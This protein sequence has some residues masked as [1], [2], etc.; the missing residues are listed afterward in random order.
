[1]KPL[2]PA[3]SYSIPGFRIRA[4]AGLLVYI[5]SLLPIFSFAQVGRPFIKN[6]SSEEIGAAAQ[7]WCI[8]QDSVG[9]LYF[10]NSLGVIGFNGIDWNLKQVSNTS[11]VR[12]L[13]Y[14]PVTDRLY[15]G[16]QGEFGYFEKDSLGNRK[17]V[18]LL[19]QVPDEDKNFKDIWKTYI[20]P[21]GIYFQSW[22]QVFRWNGDEMDIWKPEGRFHQSFFVDNTFWIKENE[23]GLLLMDHDTLHLPKGGEF[24]ASL[25]IYSL[26]PWKNGS[27]I[28]GTREAGFFILSYKP[29]LDSLQVR[30]IYSTEKDFILKNNLYGGVRLRNGQYLFNTTLGG[31]FFLGPEGNITRNLNKSNGLDIDNIKAIFEDRDGSIWLATNSGITR[32]DYND[33]VTYLGEI[34]NLN[35]E[36]FAVNIFEDKI[37]AG[38]GQG[39]FIFDGQNFEKAEGLEDLCWDIEKIEFKGE[40][41]L[42]FSNQNGIFQWNSGR[43]LKVSDH[44]AYNLYHSKAHPGHVLAGDVILKIT[45]GRWRVAY[46]FD[47]MVGDILTNTEDCHSNQWYSTRRHGIY[48]IGAHDYN[49]AAYLIHHYDTTKGLPN[50]LYPRVYI[51]NCDI[52]AWTTE[53]IYKFDPENHHFYF[54]SILNELTTIPGGDVLSLA[55]DKGDGLWAYSENNDIQELSMK[56]AIIDQDGNIQI[57]DLSALKKS[58]RIN[59][60]NIH[61][62]DDIFWISSSQGIARYDFSKSQSFSTGKGFISTIDWLPIDV[63]NESKIIDD[64]SSGLKLKILKEGLD[65]P[66][67][68]ILPRE[69]KQILPFKLNSVIFDFTSIYYKNPEKLSYRYKLTG[70]EK[71]WSGWVRENSK[72]YFNLP[73]GEYE[74]QLETRNVYGA[75]GRPV[76][77]AFEVLPPWYRTIPA[78]IGYVLFFGLSLFGAARISAIRLRQQ[79]KR[80]ERV[81]NERTKEIRHQKEEIEVKN[82]EL[83]QQKEEIQ[84]TAENLKEAN[85]SIAEQNSLIEKKNLDITDSILYAKYIQEA[86]LPQMNEIRKA[87]D[88]SFV[89]FKPK[90][91][92]SGDFF[93]FGETEEVKIVAAVD[94]TGH[95]VPG[96]FMSMLGSTLLHQVIF[97]KGL[98]EADKILNSLNDGVRKSLSQQ[99]SQNRDGM[100]IALCLIHKKENKIEF[101]GAKNPLLLIDKKEGL[102]TIKGDKFPIGGYQHE[103]EVNFTRH[104]IEIKESTFVCLFSDGFQD[105]FG[106]PKGKKYMIRQLKEDFQKI[107]DKSGLEQQAYLDKKFNDWKGSQEQLDD[108]LVIGFKVEPK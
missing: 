4:Y 96:A 46:K 107:W 9:T 74:F 106:G 15:A 73:E 6:F 75:K 84:A 67:N 24:F 40:E 65:L 54:D 39:V 102:Q 31:I 18:S 5:F 101:A 50:L 32:L 25:R 62:E 82:S 103:G 63:E 55:V 76:S 21:D 7:N 8:Q 1:L 17:Y 10:G 71:E 22:T 43:P 86:M 59:L 53:G 79:K 95:G 37:F 49:T 92:V 58:H 104:L 93:W 70:K 14:D 66:D 94:C 91:I 89:L 60:N 108:I 57:Q 16:A 13:A 34:E 80:L 29:F 98:T 47:G 97:E 87:L 2:L 99:D 68:F 41:S 45:D 51:W 12:S 27:M 3:P 35:G 44:Y 64:L 11:T 48:Q 88:E 42:L 105:Q 56:R 83:E 100:D 69:G 33:P 23:V 85:E 90:D 36:V 52:Y 77:L 38:T 81:V 72:T 20:R 78:Y 61:Q 26:L 28:A 30:P 19:A